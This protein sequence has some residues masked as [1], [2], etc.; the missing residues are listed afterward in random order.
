[1]SEPPKPPIAADAKEFAD[2]VESSGQT[3]AEIA[4]Y[5]QRRL[6]RAV[7]N[8][9]VS[10]W[11]GGKTGLPADVLDA[12]RERVAQ[13][14]SGAAAGLSTAFAT[15]GLTDTTDVVP[16]F[17]YANAAGSTLRLNED[18]Q[19]GVVPIHPA[20]RGSRQAFAFIVFGDSISPRMSHGDIGYSIRGRPPLK[21]KPCIVE[22]ANGEVLVKIF[23]GM[24]DRTLFLSQLE[25]AKSLSIPLRDVS[26]VHAVVGSTFG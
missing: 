10:R 8:V 3:Q 24:D 2:L 1:M 7:N 20:Q 17:G 19:V 5:L 22:L 26:A 13:P 4:T 6:G 11:A 9:H 15:L 16:L 18:Q 12:M 21:G 25:P 23:E 14:L